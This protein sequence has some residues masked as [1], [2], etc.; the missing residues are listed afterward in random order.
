MNA[1]GGAEFIGQ[2]RSAFIDYLKH[3]MGE[4]VYRRPALPVGGEPRGDKGRY[5][6]RARPGG[7][8]PV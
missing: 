4:H 2:E 5:R 8:P 7:Y 6:E 3:K 1:S